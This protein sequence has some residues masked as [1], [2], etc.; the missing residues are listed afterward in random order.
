MATCRAITDLSIVN[1]ILN[2]ANVAE[3]DPEDD[4]IDDDSMEVRVPSPSDVD[5]FFIGLRVFL[6]ANPK[7]TTSLLTELD[8]FQ[9]KMDQFREANLTQ[10]TIDSF[11]RF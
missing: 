4:P 1:D 10:P 2:E 11:I 3:P 8:K 7:N 6:Q 5:S 9:E